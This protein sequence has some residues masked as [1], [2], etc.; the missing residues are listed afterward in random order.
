[1]QSTHWLFVT[2]NIIAFVIFFLSDPMRSRKG[3]LQVVGEYLKSVWENVWQLATQHEQISTHIVFMTSFIS[4]ILSFSLLFLQS[5]VPPMIVEGSTSN[6]MV[7][8]EGSNVTLVCKAKGYPEPYVRKFIYTIFYRDDF[9][10]L[11]AHVRLL[12]LFVFCHFRRKLC[13]FLLMKWKIDYF[14]NRCDTL[15][16][17]RFWTQ[18]SFIPEKTVN[19]KQTFSTW[20]SINISKNLSISQHEVIKYATI[21]DFYLFNLI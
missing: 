7:V 11:D 6:D 3:Y 20:N 21:R 15:S 13:Y 5:P 10:F 16:L 14:G 1:M 18:F 4:Y 17:L 8:R 19:K 9:P 2:D 12:F